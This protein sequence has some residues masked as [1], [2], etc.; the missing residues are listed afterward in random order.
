M[1]DRQFV[2][3]FGDHAAPADWRLPASLEIL[4]KMAWARFN[5]AAAAGSY[6]PCLRLI[7]D[8]GHVAAE[9]ISEV[10]VAAGASADVSWFQGLAGSGAGGGSGLQTLVGARIEAHAPQS[11]P[12]STNTD[13]VYDTVPFDT[14]GMADLGT[15][16]RI[17]TVNTAGLYLVVCETTWDAN[18]AGR[19]LNGITV[20]GYTSGGAPFLATDSRNAVFTPVAGPGH[21]PNTC[22]GIFSAQ[23]GDFFASG[24]LQGSGVAINCNGLQ[25]GSSQDNFLSAIAIGVA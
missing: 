24:C 9:A 17:L 10:T 13:V 7:S 6:R 3:P 22:V 21:T 11:I 2:A 15:N 25:A 19:R 8:S 14:D 4:P 5:G 16:S 12:A 1:P 20:N 18:T 23:V